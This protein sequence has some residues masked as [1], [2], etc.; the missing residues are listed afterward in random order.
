MAWTATVRSNEKRDDGAIYIIVDLTDG[1][2]K[3]AKE[4]K[5]NAPF[6]S[7]EWLKEQLRNDVANQDIDQE[8]INLSLGLLDLAPK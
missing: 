3:I 8:V 6:Q 7:L 4:Y 2:T 1:N 5:I